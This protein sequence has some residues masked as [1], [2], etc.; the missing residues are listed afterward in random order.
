MPHKDPY[1]IANLSGLLQHLSFGALA[2][3]GGV[4]SYYQRFL[5][6][7]KKFRLLIFTGEIATSAL[8]GVVVF[9]IGQEFD[10]SDPMIAAFVAL[11]GYAG[12]KVLEAGETAITDRLSGVMGGSSDD[13]GGDK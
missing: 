2:I 3:W 8:A 12:G 4:V 9:Y 10:I 7:G 13:A 5:R 11:A 1:N 6:V